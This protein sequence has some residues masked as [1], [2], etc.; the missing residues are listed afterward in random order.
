MRFTSTSLLDV[1]LVDLESFEDERGTFYRTFCAREFEAQGLPA[2]FVQS[3]ISTNK[4]KGTVRGM[5][6]QKSPCKEGKLVRC[7]KGRVMDVAIDLRGTSPS[8]CQ[9][10]ACEL[11]AVSGKSIYLPPGVAHGFQALEDESNILYQMTDFYNSD[12]DAGVRWNDPLFDIKW[13]LKVAV[14]SERDESYNNYQ[15]LA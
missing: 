7:I 5:H 10:I 15:P 1:I 13:P 3:S 2:A 9:W 14:I 11:D 4:S 8:Y 12:L 6:F